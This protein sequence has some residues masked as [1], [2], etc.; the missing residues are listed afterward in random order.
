MS[1][2]ISFL[3][4][5]ILVSVTLD[6]EEES[7]DLWHLWHHHSDLSIHASVETFSDFHEWM[8]LLHVSGLLLLV[9]VL[10]H[11]SHGEFLGGGI[12]VNLLVE[13][14]DHL[15]NFSHGVREL[16]D[17]TKDLIVSEAD[18][19]S[20]ENIPH[21]VQL[22]ENWDGILDDV[23]G[24]SLVDLADFDVVHAPFVS[25]VHVVVCVAVLDVLEEHVPSAV[26]NSLQVV[27]ADTPDV[28]TVEES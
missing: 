26:G 8:L 10:V 12:E 14:P 13:V 27:V 23:T 6:S 20:P 11:L 25:E 9:N 18:I 1:R 28:S 22:S 7:W 5:K 21:A 4:I 3:K 15:A 2:L 17:L 19:F 16:S 24:D